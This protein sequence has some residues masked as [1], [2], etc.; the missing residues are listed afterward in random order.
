MP[1]E[2][3]TGICF[4]P[5]Q[6]NHGRSRVGS[7]RILGKSGKIDLSKNSLFLFFNAKFSFRP[8]EK[9]RSVDVFPWTSK[10]AS[11]NQTEW[12]K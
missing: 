6:K 11:V 10:N 1:F 5:H 7:V 4:V 2:V 3:P 9:N 12:D 8:A